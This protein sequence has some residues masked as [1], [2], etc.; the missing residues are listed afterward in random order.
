MTNKA[1]QMAKLKR[2]G[3][4]NKRAAEQQSPPR[5]AT[6]KVGLDSPSNLLFYPPAESAGKPAVTQNIL[7][8]D[9]KPDDSKPSQP[10]GQSSQ[11]ASAREA[12][13]TAV[14]KQQPTDL[15]APAS[16]QHLAD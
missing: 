15:Y 1:Q 4:A 9:D 6:L 5:E 14:G 10:S 12:G 16:N 3:T 11:I 2:P 8:L 7:V 13:G